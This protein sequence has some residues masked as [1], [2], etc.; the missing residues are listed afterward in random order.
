MSFDKKISFE[1][2]DDAFGRLDE[3]ADEKF[4]AIPRFV[5]HIDYAA[6]DAVTDVYR[7]N[8]PENGDILDLMSSML[9]H[10]PEEIDYNSVTGLGMNEREM[11]HNKQLDTWVVHNLNDDP[12]LP[13]HDN[14]FDAGV[15]C[16]SIDYLTNP[17]AVLKDTGRTLK[18]GAPLIITYSNRYFEAKA[19]SV[20]LRLDDEQRGYLI[21]SF[22]AEAGSFE[23]IQIADCSPE[24]GDPLYTVIAKNI[25]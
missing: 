14:Q 20:W 23:N 19:T 25:A 6:I 15:I 8:L 12:R 10:L 5:A 21:K 3:V 16:V 13:F 11:F 4:Y 9:S 2:P 22:L 24:F 7:R 17:V 1:L 18:N